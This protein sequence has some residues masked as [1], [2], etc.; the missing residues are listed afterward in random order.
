M[1]RNFATSILIIWIFAYIVS[2]SEAE[3]GAA[4]A[5]LAGK[6]FTVFFWIWIPLIAI[7]ILQALY[8]FSKDSEN[9]LEK[10]R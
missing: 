7:I 5:E 3:V 9:P 10:W 4:K 1:N 8:T 6:I 2:I